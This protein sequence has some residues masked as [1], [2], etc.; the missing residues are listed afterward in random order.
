MTQEERAKL[1]MLSTT[2]LSDALES[3]GLRPGVYGVTPTWDGCKKIAG[4]A[5]TVRL[6]PAGQITPKTHLGI[7]A[8]EAAKPGDVILVDN[9]GRLDISCWGGVLATGASLKGI[10]GVVIDGSCRDI[11]DYV[12]LGF[13]VYSRGKVV[14]TARGKAIEEATNIPVQFCGVQVCPGDIVMADRS[15]VV[16]IPAACFTEVLEKAITL[17]EKEEAMCADLRAGM[18]SL[19]VDTKYNYNKMLK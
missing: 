6:I 4:E 7:A 10:S 5:V 18:S 16:I 12:E 14:A 13:S 2:N 8:I 11:D 17:F 9:G 3:L 15:G 1:M 19:E